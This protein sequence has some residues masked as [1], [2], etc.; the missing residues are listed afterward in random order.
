MRPWRF[1]T[2]NRVIWLLKIVQ[3]A[4]SMRPWRFATDNL[5]VKLSAYTSGSRFNEAV[6]FCHG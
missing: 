3:C 1:A 5:T 6:A 4:A 2:D